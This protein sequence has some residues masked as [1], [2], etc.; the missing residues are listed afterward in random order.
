ML[1]MN[2]KNRINGSYRKMMVDGEMQGVL[3]IDG[4]LNF[5]LI[6][7]ISEQGIDVLEM[8]TRGVFNLPF[9]LSD[10]LS[11]EIKKIQN[12]T[13]T[14]KIVDNMLTEQDTTMQQLWALRYT[15][16][17]VEKSIKPFKNQITVLKQ[18]LDKSI[19][20]EKATNN[21][22]NV[23]INREKELNDKLSKQA[24]QHDKEVRVLEHRI[25]ELEKEL[26]RT[27]KVM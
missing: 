22:W 9:V 10:D 18:E 17:A 13:D 19:Q 8:I 11:E 7:C 24:K 12:C 15:E 3:N 5:G 27:E 21:L 6:T 1:D 20:K 14:M 2:K 23:A 25:Q 16:L 26:Y 4:V